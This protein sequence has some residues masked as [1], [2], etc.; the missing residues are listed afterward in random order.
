MHLKSKVGFTRAEKGAMEFLA[1][2]L[3]QSQGPVFV[4][5][6]EKIREMQRPVGRKIDDR[7]DFLGFGLRVG[8]HGWAE[9]VLTQTIAR[10][11]ARQQGEYLFV[12][13]E[14][15]APFEG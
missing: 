10:N 7:P 9:M 6:G 8:G 11:G 5:L 4:E 1:R 2:F 12:R 15:S 13:H 14:W 3:Q